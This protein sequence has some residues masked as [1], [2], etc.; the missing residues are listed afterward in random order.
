MSGEK[1]AQTRLTAEREAVL[2]RSQR[3]NAELA[4][5]QTVR[6]RLTAEFQEFTASYGAD[7]AR[8]MAEEY[9]SCKQAS[10][11]IEALDGKIEALD[12]KAQSLAMPVSQ[13]E[14][15]HFEQV[16]GRLE[17]DKTAQ[18]TE[19]QTA[20]ETLRQGME[21]I[22]TNLQSRMDAAERERRIQA[23]RRA[24][25]RGIADAFIERARIDTAMRRVRGKVEERLASA[26][27]SESVEESDVERFSQEIDQLVQDAWES[28][29]KARRQQ[30]TADL[31]RDAFE[32]AGFAKK[33]DT[34]ASRQDGQE[35]H[36]VHEASQA[37]LFVRISSSIPEDQ[38]IK[39][40]ME[41]A[42]GRDSERLEPAEYCGDSLD[43]II[44][45][46]RELGVIIEGVTMK[47]PD[48]L[49]R[50]LY[51]EDERERQR[52]EDEERMFQDDTA[53]QQLAQQGGAR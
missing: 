11:H 25:L 36:L 42:A 47:G 52:M 32:E 24:R 23:E 13:S 35:I 22:R 16:L 10:A 14:L 18:S 28:D 39:L 48:G 45:R 3:L 12:R 9:Q 6:T 44:R 41:G 20:R 37:D 53:F 1:Y 8:Y 49:W 17:R 34:P 30:H 26:E 51:T 31:L 46:A 19:Q 38:S 21:S 2:Q 40:V 29:L 50:N 7:A 33:E 43:D 4:Q 15:N 27:A 5:M